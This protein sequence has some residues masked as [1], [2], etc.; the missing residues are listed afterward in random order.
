M[1]A[2]TDS[3]NSNGFAQSKDIQKFTSYQVF[4]VTIIALMQFTI[5]LDFM[6]ISPLG[7]ILK[8]S[9][10]ISNKQ[11]GLLVSVYAVSA[12]VSG[13][14]AAGFADKYDRKKTLMFF[15]AGFVLGTFFCGLANSYYTLLLARVMT[16]IFGGVIGSVGM[17]IITDLFSLT[18]R[19]RAMGFVQMAFAGSQVL[20]LP[21]GIMIANHYNWHA[22]FYMI[23]ILAMLIG[24]LIVFKLKPITAH[25][26]LQNESR[27][28]KHLL[29]AVKNE[30][31][32]KGYF[33]MALLSL[34]GFMIM[35]Y[36]VVFL[37][38]NV[39]IN[40]STIP[41]IYF[42]TGIASMIIM[43]LIG[44]LSD[45]VNKVTLFA[46]GSLLAAIMIL[47][48]TNLTIVPTWMVIVV[49]VLL[50]MG[51]MGRVV[52]ATIINSSIPAAADRGAYMSVS[53]SLQQMAGGLASVVGGV[54][55]I[56]KTPSS[57]YENF[58]VLGVIMAILMIWC[59]YLVN[60]L[61]QLTLAKG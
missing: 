60:K 12:A 36:T 4:V 28:I 48:F 61:S 59:I 51:I 24:V 18:Q 9:L 44:K 17:A 52:P 34:G 50:F 30:K 47:V 38:N 32:R 7:D 8:K 26:A 53:S 56:Q 27:A 22:T 42:F 39:K 45:R 29:A 25:L 43:P 31:Y 35:P 21:L 33:V 54:V 57:P 19:G 6:I 2:S 23:V 5:V 46:T 40:E 58:Y 3:E 41:T 14:L 10:F 55:L 13:F 37:I 49:N 20:G 16:G 11:F 1:K 15:Y